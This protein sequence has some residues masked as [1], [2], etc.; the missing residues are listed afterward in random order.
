MTRTGTPAGD[1]VLRE[2]ARRMREAIRTYD[3]IGRYGG[4]EFL[5]VAPGYNLAAA[6]KEAEGLRPC[7]AADP[8]TIPGGPISVTASLGVAQATSALRQA[9]IACR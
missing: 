3:V 7:L 6:E 4:E 2:S 8:L 5:V 1:A 9:A